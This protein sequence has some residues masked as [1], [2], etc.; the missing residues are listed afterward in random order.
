M[1]MTRRLALVPFLLLMGIVVL[2]FIHPSIPKSVYVVRGQ[3]FRYSLDA[4]I[5]ALVMIMTPVWLFLRGMVNKKN[6]I[7]TMLQSICMS[8]SIHL[9]IVVG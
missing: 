5:P 2:S 3:R 4:R 9:W 6:V 1:S 8:V 7:C